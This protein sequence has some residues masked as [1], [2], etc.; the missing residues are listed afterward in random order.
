MPA[1]RGRSRSSGSAASIAPSR[2]VRSA[3][4]SRIRVSGVRGAAD[5]VQRRRRVDIVRYRLR[6][7]HA[8]GEPAERRRDLRHRQLFPGAGPSP[9]SRRRAPDRR[10]RRRPRAAARRR[11]QPRAVGEHFD[12]R[13][14]DVIGRAMKVNGV[15]V[16]IVGVAPRRFAGAR[17]GGSQMR[18]WLPLSTRSQ[19][20]RTTSTLTSYDDARFGL[21]ARLQPGVLAEE[22]GPTVEAIAARASLQATSRHRRVHR[23]RPADR[24]QLLS[25]IGR[26]GGPRPVSILMFPV[27]VLLITCTNVSAAARRS[28]RRAPARDRRAAGARRRP[29]PHRSTTRDRDRD[30]G[31]GRRCAG[32]FVIWL[33]SVCSMPA[34]RTW[35]SRS[36]GAVSRSRSA[37]ALVAGCCSILAG[38]ARDRLALQEALK[39]SAG[40][41]V[42]RRTA[43]VMAGGCPDRL[44]PACAAGHGR[45]AAGDALGPA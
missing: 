25:A 28:R 31:D 2:V 34:F 15:T 16:T 6:R 40:V 7:R 38:A 42:A 4:S 21:A 18:V 19:V 1:S 5:A 45:G 43:A 12:E 11:D 35:R 30:A 3:A 8:R 20:Q 9:G 13:S 33:S 32:L 24:Q 37:L 10:E 17:T 29:P 44:H 22:T 36:T 41:V 39:D 26:R 23:R 14:P 27:L